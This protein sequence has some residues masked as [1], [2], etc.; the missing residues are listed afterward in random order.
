MLKRALTVCL[1][2]WARIFENRSHNCLI[3]VQQIILTNACT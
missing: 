3:I 1:P 2:T